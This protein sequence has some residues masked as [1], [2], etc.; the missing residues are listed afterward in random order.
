MCCRSLLW[1][2]SSSSLASEREVFFLNFRYLPYWAHS[3]VIH[4]KVIS[5]CIFFSKNSFKSL[6]PIL[7]LIYSLS[8]WHLCFEPCRSLC[9]VCCSVDAY[10]LFRHQR[11]KFFLARKCLSHTIWLFSTTW[12]GSITGSVSY[13]RL[14]IGVAIL[15]RSI[16]CYFPDSSNRHLKSS[17]R[18][19]KSLFNS[20]RTILRFLFFIFQ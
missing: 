3:V 11:K 19:L 1:S 14:P 8:Y 4:P 6:F 16:F 10:Q 7:S 9:C 12:Q 5:T 15:V 20:D 18:H 2:F 13:L 17:N